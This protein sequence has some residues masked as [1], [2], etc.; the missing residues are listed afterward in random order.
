MLAHRYAGSRGVLF[1]FVC[2][3][4][5]LSRLLI[6]KYNPFSFL[7]A[8]VVSIVDSSSFPSKI[9]NFEFKL[10]SPHVQILFECRLSSVQAHYPVG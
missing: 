3:D 5:V 4:N 1:L 2:V 8:R 10:P 7:D 6:G 9:L